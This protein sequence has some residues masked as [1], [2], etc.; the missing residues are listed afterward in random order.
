MERPFVYVENNQPTVL[1]L[2][3]KKRDDSYTILYLLVRV[4]KYGHQTL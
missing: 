2:A 1:Y 3:I 4:F